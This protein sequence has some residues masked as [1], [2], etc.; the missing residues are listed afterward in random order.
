MKTFFQ[1]M[2]ITILFALFTTHAAANLSCETT[3]VGK[4]N[5][6]YDKK[7]IIVSKSC[8][9]FTINFKYD[10]KL[11]K[12]AMGHNLVITKKSDMTAVGTAALQRGPQNDYSPAKEDKRVI[13]ASSKL[14]GGGK[15]DPKEDTVVLDTSRLNSK[16]EYMFFCT[17]PGHV[18][19]MQGKLKVEEGKAPVKKAPVKKAPEATKAPSPK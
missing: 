13:A 5:M 7:E 17:F 14:L 6:Q 9:K 18:A 12:T 16:E 10:G 1:N 8:S 4:D 2:N 3:I 15:G 19:I 11:P